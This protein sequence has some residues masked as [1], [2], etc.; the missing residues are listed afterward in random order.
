[1]SNL[2]SA[3]YEFIRVK[4]IGYVSVLP[5]LLKVEDI[6]VESVVT[7]DAEATVMKAVELM[8]EHEIGCIIVTRRGKPVG[9]VT[10]RDLLRRVIAKAKNPNKT[11]V[12]E[13]MT[14]PLV[15]GRPDMDAEEATRLM[16]EN[17]IKKLPII[18]NG[19]LIGLITLT[20]IARFQPQVIRILKKLSAHTAPPRRLKKVMDYYVV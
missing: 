14:K 13:I 1:M 7:V 4:A 5:L 8:N 9:I 2:D 6:M 16:F 18:E 11:K 19:Q 15:Y 17:K 12:R 3:F 20:D 10:E